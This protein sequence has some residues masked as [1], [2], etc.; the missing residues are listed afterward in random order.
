RVE[1]RSYGLADEPIGSLLSVRP[2]YSRSRYCFGAL[3]QE[4]S[5]MPCASQVSIGRNGPRASRRL[6]VS[7]GLSGLRQFPRARCQAA[8]SSGGGFWGGPVLE[9]GVLFF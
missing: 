9:R 8:S 4:I 3:A 5:G 7:P 6:C 1:A 2:W